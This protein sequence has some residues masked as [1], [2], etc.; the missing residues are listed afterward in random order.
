M[1]EY[2]QC[3]GLQQNNINLNMTNAVVLVMLLFY[4]VKQGVYDL[5]KQRGVIKAGC[6]DC[7]THDMG[8]GLHFTA[9]DNI[10]SEKRSN[11]LRNVAL[12][13]AD[14]DKIANFAV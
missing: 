10:K 1:K 12:N 3:V 13:L 9:S 5:E 11:P 6:R 4:R 14:W 8:T 7:D 2:A